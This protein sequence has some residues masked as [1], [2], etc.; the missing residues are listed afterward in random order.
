MKDFSG[1][2]T[3]L[4]PAFNEGERI[5]DNIKETEKVFQE[6]GCRY[7][8]IVIDDGSSDDT[9]NQSL[10]AARENSHVQVLKLHENQGKGFA[11]KSGFQKASGDLI[12][13]LD[14][15]LDLHPSQIQSLLD[16]MRKT[17]ADVVTGSK[18]HADSTLNYPLRRV[19]LSDFYAILLL[20]LFRLPLRDT[21][22]GLKI[23]KAEVLKEIF[24]KILCKRYAFDVEILANT[25]HQG[26]KIVEA[27]IV[28]TFRREMKWG[29]MRWADLY[30]TGIDTLAIFYRM[31]LLKFYD[32]A[33]LPVEEFPM[34]SI[35]IPTRTMNPHLRETLDQCK[36]LDYPDY[37]VIVLPDDEF[38][39]SYSNPMFRQVPTGP[40]GP[41][42][43]RDKGAGDARGS[44]LAFLDDDAY[45]DRE[46]LRNA[47]RS[48]GEEVVSAV[49]GP[50][51]TP[52]SDSVMQ[53]ASGAVFS[54]WMVGGT[55]SYR[56]IPK[57]HLEVKDYPTCNLL[58]R[59]NDFEKINGFD[60]KFWPG[61][62][63]ILCLKIIRDLKKKIVYDPD[64]LVYHH[65][66]PLFRSHLQQVK[67]YALHR[68]YFAK[69]FPETSLRFSYFLPTLFVLGAST[70]W[71]SYWLHPLLFKLYLWIMGFY[72][73]C[74]LL[75]SIKEF[76]WKKALAIFGGIIS[77]HAV[78]GIWFVK[79]LLTGRLKEE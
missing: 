59:K 17:G 36:E 40:V 43:K 50:A 53:K 56:Y 30:W 65:R 21:Q 18:R 33:I 69:R 58:V 22:T 71:A 24:P 74:A 31:H 3:V 19:V 12:I 2:I 1:K 25:H 45:P 62:D 37:E 47:A 72:L 39:W 78:Y 70:G 63:T 35:I 51:V 41:A 26:Y 16:V 67:S 9:Y 8:L 49:G 61:E 32:R 52:E 77:S 5:Y 46:W 7:E 4:M 27:P 6:A 68:G 55:Y 79:G 75:T 13:F 66:R 73:V 38:S 15:D 14:A 76:H 54:S 20:L 48:F 64:V 11:L 29:R 28:L 60:T 42:D 34:I 44:I 10:K 23:F 57:I